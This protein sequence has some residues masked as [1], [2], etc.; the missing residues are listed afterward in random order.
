MEALK[1]EG[2]RF[3]RLLVLERAE[4]YRGKTAW[5]CECDCGKRT[6][7]TGRALVSG[8][9][10]SCGCLRKENILKATKTH[11]MSRGKY[12]QVW[13][14]IKQRCNNPHNREWK[15]YGGRG[16][17]ICKE[18]ECDFKAFY[19][20]IS[21]LPH[22]NESGYTIDRID[23]NKGY[24][25]GNLRWATWHQQVMNRRNTVHVEYEGEEYTLPD[26]AEKFDVSY[27]SILKRR[28]RGQPL[29]K[30]RSE[31]CN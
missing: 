25:P 10:Q 8:N 16:I 26:L 29:I 1:L 23:N 3:T 15:N 31:K 19:E 6:I 4:N 11:G 24:E 18:W 14:A 9:T 12:Y 20:Y 7:V 13:M 28:F 17:K 27:S 21:A 22:F 2:R 30:E 5:L